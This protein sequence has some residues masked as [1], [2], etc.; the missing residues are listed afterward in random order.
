MS[1][2]YKSAVRDLEAGQLASV[3]LVIGDEEWSRE[4][5]L[6]LLKSK[7]VDPEMADFN[8][9]QLVANETK[10]Q[11]AV[12][13]ACELPMMSDRRMVMVTDCEKW[14]A[15][16][17]DAVTKYLADPNDQACLVLLFT[18][19]D[20]RRKLFQSRSKAVRSLEFARPKSWELNDTIRD[21]A[22]DMKLKLT[23]EAVVMIADLAGDDLAKVSRELEKLSLYKLG[24]SQIT[25]DDVEALMGRTRHVTRWELNDFIG[26]RD[27]GGALLKLHAI[28]ASGEDPI[29][30]L[31]AVNMHIKRLFTVKT[32]L[33]KGIK[34]N[35]MI[36]QAVGVPPRV[37][38]NLVDQQRAYSDCEMRAAFKI[39]RDTDI[40][41]KSAAMNK[42]LLLDHLLTQIM[43]IGPLSPPR[44]PPR[45]QRR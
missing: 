43:A 6:K 45:S 7:V 29:G 21:L 25:K 3:Y 15:K 33:M 2:V 40:R 22:L 23:Q 36:A 24:S 4:R 11:V 16:D 30:L 27:L 20:K 8:Y 39:M 14:K 42:K 10:G 41:L 44:S 13:K 31:S 5:F 38:G 17:L 34:D 28:I 32:L 12:D 35:G 9:D 37:A 18:S 1:K 19:A 26:K